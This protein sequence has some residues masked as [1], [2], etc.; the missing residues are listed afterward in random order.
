MIARLHIASP[1]IFS[2]EL[3]PAIASSSRIPSIEI[4]NTIPPGNP[5]NGINPATIHAIVMK[6]SF[7]RTYART[8]AISGRF[9][10]AIK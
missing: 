5:S 3:I 4:A 9:R 6:I 1:G 8:I 2:K 10:C 7:N